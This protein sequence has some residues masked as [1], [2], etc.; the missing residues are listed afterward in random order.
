MNFI[1]VVIGEVHV[2]VCAVK[3]FFTSI[4]AC[5]ERDR[6]GDDTP[7]TSPAPGQCFCSQQLKGTWP[8]IRIP[9]SEAS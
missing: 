9:T 6:L 5:V 1:L 4:F 7:P 8:V 3:D 2:P